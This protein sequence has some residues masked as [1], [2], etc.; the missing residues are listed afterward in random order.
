MKMANEE[1]LTA[2]D[3]IGQMADGLKE[4]TDY[5]FTRWARPTKRFLRRN[6]VCLPAEVR[7]IR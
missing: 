1:N 3:Y 2:E 5:T 7:N 6:Y 4:V